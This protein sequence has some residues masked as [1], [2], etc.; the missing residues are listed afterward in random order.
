MN[1]EE[2]RTFEL[3]MRARQASIPVNDRCEECE[4]AGHVSIGCGF[5][6]SVYGTCPA[7]DGSGQQ[8]DATRHEELEAHMASLLAQNNRA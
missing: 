4:G 7:C 5:T 1:F 3:G 2:T 8:A 6:K